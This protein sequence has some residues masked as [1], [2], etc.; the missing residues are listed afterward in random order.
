VTVIRPVYITERGDQVTNW[1]NATEHTVTGCR[2]QPASGQD[3]QSATRDAVIDR[4]T[5]FAPAAA[6]IDVR[7]RIRYGG[8][9]YEIDGNLRHWPSPSGALAHTEATLKHVGG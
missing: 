2:V 4:W 1:D 7:D 6:D 9:V 8:T 3:V 5:L